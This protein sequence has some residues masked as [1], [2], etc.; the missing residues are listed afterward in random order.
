MPPCRAQ[1]ISVLSDNTS[2]GVIALST[3]RILRLALLGLGLLPASVAPAGSQQPGNLTP[4]DDRFAWYEEHVR[5][6]AS[7]PLKHLP[8]QFLGPTNISGRM[9]DV[10]VVTPRGQSYTLFVAG[11]SGGV[12]RSRNGGVSWKPVFERGVSTSIGDVTIAPSN[13]D[14]VWIGTG[15]ATPEQCFFLLFQNP[16]NFSP[17]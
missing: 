1:G 5:M 4:P 3:L 2:F 12:W 15:E 7:S 14:I 16:K 13:Q 17:P 10:A 9:T 11:A 8:W 6:A